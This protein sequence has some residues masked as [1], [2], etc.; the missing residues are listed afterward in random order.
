[1]AAGSVHEQMIMSLSLHDR[2][3]LADAA[4][5]HGRWM[6]RADYDGVS[7]NKKAGGFRWPA[8][9][10]RM[11]ERWRQRQDLRELDDRLLRDIGITREQA[12]REANKSFWR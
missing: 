6:T 3:A 1:M 11:R 7:P 12:R 4:V 2:S 10:R 8:A 9:L 5:R